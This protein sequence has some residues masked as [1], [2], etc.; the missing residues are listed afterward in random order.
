MKQSYLQVFR[1]FYR[2]LNHISNIIKNS[3]KLDYDNLSTKAYKR[4]LQPCVSE[5][6]EFGVGKKCTTMLLV[7]HCHLMAEHQLQKKKVTH[8]VE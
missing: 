3:I 7:F 6:G 5:T 8:K 1:Q 2:L 4:S